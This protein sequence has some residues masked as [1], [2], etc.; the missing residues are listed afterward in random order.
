MQRAGG[1]SKR[2][3]GAFLT[4]VGSGIVSGEWLRSKLARGQALKILDASWCVGNKGGGGV[5]S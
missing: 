4:R 1:F 2:G 5:R 3:G